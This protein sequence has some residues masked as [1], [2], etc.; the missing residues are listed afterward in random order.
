[1]QLH[2]SVKG[3]KKLVNGSSGED[4]SVGATIPNVKSLP[5]NN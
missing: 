5:A 3:V 1:M 4:F 2:D